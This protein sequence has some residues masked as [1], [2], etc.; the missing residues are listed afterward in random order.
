[1]SLADDLRR[2]ELVALDRGEAAIAQ[3]I[4]SIC[5]RPK[6]SASDTALLAP[7]L[8]WCKNASARHCPAKPA[9]VAAYTLELQTRG[10]AQERILAELGAI[11]GPTQSLWFIEPDPHA[12]R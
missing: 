12:H 3:A 2:A 8:A 5:E 6:L 10:V 7:Y 9:T 11:R 1:M 4:A